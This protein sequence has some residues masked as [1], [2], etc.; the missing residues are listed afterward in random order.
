MTNKSELL[1][2][3]V[4]SGPVIVKTREKLFVNTS[5]TYQYILDSNS[6]GDLLHT[7]CSKWS[8]RQAVL[9]NEGAGFKSIT[10]EDFHRMVFEVACGLE[11]LG[12]KKG[13]RVA[14]ISENCL[15]W[16]LLDWACQT[17]GYVTVPIYTTLPPDQ[18]EFILKDAQIYF[19]FVGNEQIQKK[20]LDIKGVKSYI[21]KTKDGKSQH[22]D[23]KEFLKE[24]V[25]AMTHKQWKETTA[26]IDKSDVAT[27]I[28]TSGT[29]GRPK[30]VM[31]ENK[32][33][34]H[35]CYAAQRVLPINQKD[36]YLS[37][38]PLSHVFE[39]A[40]GHI[41]PTSLGA[42]VA[43]V[44]NIAS[45]TSDLQSVKPEVMLC[46]P[47]LLEAIQKKIL[48]NVAKQSAIHQFLFKLA[49][50]QG[51][52]K[53]QGKFAPL[54]W[55][56]DR[57]VGKK[58]RAR[59]G[60]NIRY[61]VSGG[62]AL[63]PEVSNFFLAFGFNMIQGYGLT[64]TCAYTTL[65][66]PERNNV[67]SVGEAAWGIDIKIAD[68][69]EILVKGP[70]VM[71]G[72]YNLPKETS[73]VI[74]EEGWFHTGDVGEFRGKHLVIT[75][76]KKDLIILG[77]GKNVAPQP[78]ENK[79]KQKSLIQE[80]VLFGDKSE[81]LCG[82]FVLD[83]ESVRKKLQELGRQ[84]IL[85]STWPKSD[86]V[87]SMLKEQISEVNKNLAT[88][89]KVKRFEIISDKFSVETGELTPSMKVK[90]KVVKQKYNELI[91]SML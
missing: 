84:D 31:L 32:S 76:R 66:H 23:F 67:E 21:I 37:F 86:V 46:V 62:A 18:M 4:V 48:D 40:V 35:V 10:Y 5:K 91:E 53:A 17:M 59:T 19:A 43:Y 83:T 79:L 68:D 82:L 81:C 44:Q 13:D 26:K 12:I 70:V 58:I 63:E 69:G 56:T 20:L 50:D 49:F 47:R 25:G 39:R 3:K 89:E 54:V 90:R 6:L 87:R 45:L 65:N 15:E 22:A 36:T 7:T 1:S 73:E 24:G 8:Q 11:N 78:I 33:F 51:L 88:Y 14:I 80:A 42:C 41:L 16:S 29:T 61:F 77:N 64:E 9:R 34:L 74:D 85:E 38:L 30:G 55:L 28:Y 71:Q 75:D 57:L 60:G 2:K 52:K 72:Y 27:I